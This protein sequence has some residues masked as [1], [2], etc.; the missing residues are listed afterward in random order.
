MEHVYP[1]QL[2][3]GI[4]ELYLRHFGLGRVAYIP[5]DI[6]RT[7]WQIMNFDHSILLQNIIRWALGDTVPV[8]VE[9]PGVLDVTVW[10]QQQS[11]TVHLVNFTNPMMLKGP[12]REL[13]P[14]GKQKLE[15]RI[16]EDVNAKKVY[17]LAAGVEPLYEINGNQVSITIDQ[18]LD[19][20][21]IAVDF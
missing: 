20:E 7:C 2:D 3:S 12:F 10:R 9:G 5:W 14:V 13:L 19:H 18:I 4:R 15:L 11:M 16:P 1:L 17:L 6:D 8:S 21:V